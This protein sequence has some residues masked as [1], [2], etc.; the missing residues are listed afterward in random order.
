MF[1]P[2]SKIRGTYS[3][4]RETCTAEQSHESPQK[5]KSNLFSF[6]CPVLAPQV[7]RYCARWLDEKAQLRR[8]EFAVKRLL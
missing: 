7:R 1:L 2:L 6:I 5:F 4:K 8:K 3:V